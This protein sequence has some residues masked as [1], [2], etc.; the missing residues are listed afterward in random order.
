MV[1]HRKPVVEN[2]KDNEKE[3]KRLTIF[4]PA[5]DLIWNYRMRLEKRREISTTEGSKSL[6]SGI[7]HRNLTVVSKG[8]S[9]TTRT[10]LESEEHLTHAQNI[11]REGE[12]QEKVH[13]KKEKVERFRAGKSEKFYGKRIV[14]GC[15]VRV[16]SRMKARENQRSIPGKK[17]NG[18]GSR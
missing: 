7:D 4:A 3:H 9:I 16:K 8:G 6:T 17:R 1:I 12:T 14:S 5:H 11:G 2:G 10:R 18:D 15:L 13:Q